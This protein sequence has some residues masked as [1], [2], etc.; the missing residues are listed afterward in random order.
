[1]TIEEPNIVEAGKS[2]IKRLQTMVRAS[3]KAT[4]TPKA[5]IDEWLLSDDI[6]GWFENRIEMEN[7]TKVKGVN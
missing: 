1:M 6:I 3:R 5:F 2:L 4:S 7:Q